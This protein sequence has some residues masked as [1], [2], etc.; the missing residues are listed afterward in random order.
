LGPASTRHRVGQLPRLRTPDFVYFVSHF[1]ES[2]AKLFWR[3]HDWVID[4]LWKFVM[5]DEKHSP[6]WLAPV[7][8]EST[9][10][11]DCLRHGQGITAEQKDLPASHCFI[12][13]TLELP[14]EVNRR[15]CKRISYPGGSI[16]KADVTKVL[17]SPGPSS[18]GGVSLS[19]PPRSPPGMLDFF[20]A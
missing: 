15:A 3:T 20:R 8:L 5:R 6:L 14:Q 13:T 2:L 17:A 16:F 4:R 12:R 9:R 7:D 10:L 1:R 11:G 19:R 18:A